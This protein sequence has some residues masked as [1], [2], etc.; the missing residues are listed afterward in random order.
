MPDS[1]TTKKPKNA[2]PS[3]AAIGA[4]RGHLHRGAKMFDRQ[5]RPVC[6]EAEIGGVARS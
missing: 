4:A 1:R 5:R 6:A 2:A 3:A